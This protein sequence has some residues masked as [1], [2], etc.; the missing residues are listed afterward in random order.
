MID[1]NVM[2]AVGGAFDAHFITGCPEEQMSDTVSR[3]LHVSAI[4]VN[5]WL[6]ALNDGCTVVEASRRAGILRHKENG[7]LLN[8]LVRQIRCGTGCAGGS[9]RSVEWSV[10]AL[11]LT[12]ECRLTAEGRYSGQFSSSLVARAEADPCLYRYTLLNKSPMQPRRIGALL[13]KVHEQNGNT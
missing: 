6:E 8:A 7:P 2:Q 10:L 9:C 13:N 4:E 11:S 12:A 5:R 1:P 3:A